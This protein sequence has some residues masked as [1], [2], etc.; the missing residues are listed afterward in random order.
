MAY[1]AIYPRS[2]PDTQ[3]DPWTLA[4]SEGCKSELICAIISVVL[5]AI[6]GIAT[7]FCLVNGLILLDFASTSLATFGAGFLIY[8]GVTF[9]I[10]AAGNATYLGCKFLC[11]NKNNEFTYTP[12]EAK[13]QIALSVL[14]PI[15]AVPA[16]IVI[17]L[18]V[19]FSNR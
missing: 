12:N 8:S 1:D 11:N 6:A 5:T 13:I 4:S 19:V 17:G 3:L 2:T 9:S 18:S 7:Y 10:V 15:A 14:A 16:I